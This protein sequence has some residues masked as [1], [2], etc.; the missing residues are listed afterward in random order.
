MTRLQLCPMNIDNMRFL[1]GFHEMNEKHYPEI[2]D[3]NSCA[4]SCTIASNAVC[5]FAP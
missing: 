5:L 3:R 2:G 1:S 4:D